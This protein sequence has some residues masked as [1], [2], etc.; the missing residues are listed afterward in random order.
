LFIAKIA[1]I[2]KYKARTICDG[3]DSEQDT[4]R[5][6]TAVSILAILAILAMF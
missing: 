1:K 6:S 4:A 5:I 2:A 3:A